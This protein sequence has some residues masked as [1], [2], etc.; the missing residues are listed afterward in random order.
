MGFTS[1]KVP[2]AEVEIYTKTETAERELLG[3][4]L[5]SSSQVNWKN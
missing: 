1:A 4:L 2:L 5:P 3:N